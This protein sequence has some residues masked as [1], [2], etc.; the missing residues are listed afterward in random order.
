MKKIAIALLSACLVLTLS[1][2]ESEEETA[3]KAAETKKEDAAKK[4]EVERITKIAEKNKEEKA[5]KE[6]ENKA[7]EKKQSKVDE[8]EYKENIDRKLKENEAMSVLVKD[9]SV[10]NLTAKTPVVKI[11]VDQEVESQSDENKQIVIDEIGTMFL[12]TASASFNSDQEHTPQ[13]QLFY[14]NSNT[15]FAENRIVMD[16]NEFKLN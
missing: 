15:P 4:A 11:I 14:A 5:K 10:E 9:Y 8:K 16:P 1:A 3:K 13:V 6:K 7:A 12:Q 2:C